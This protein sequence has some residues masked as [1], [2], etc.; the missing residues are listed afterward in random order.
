MYFLQKSGSKLTSSVDTKGKLGGSDM[1]LCLR[2]QGKTKTA[3]YVKLK[4]YFKP[5]QQKIHRLLYTIID[6]VHMYLGYS[7]E[8]MRL[9]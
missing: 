1:C 3:D 2:L 6:Y 7:Q 5:V 9:T 4:A 8:Q